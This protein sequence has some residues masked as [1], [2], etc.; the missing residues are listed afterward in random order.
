MTIASDQTK[1]VSNQTQITTTKPE[2]EISPTPYS[3]EVRPAQGQGLLSSTAVA[4]LVG[5]FLFVS[6]LALV[7]VAS[8]V[9]PN[10]P[11][12]REALDTEEERTANRRLVRELVEGIILTAILFSV[13]V[14]G[15]QNALDRNSINSIIAGIVGYVAGRVASQK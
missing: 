6:L 8:R 10:T 1:I 15:L 7:Y 5:T 3:S 12:E 2:S 11:E 4:V 14:L 9:L 13:M